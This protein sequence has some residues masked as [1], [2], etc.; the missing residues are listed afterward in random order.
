MT[1]NS[2]DLKELPTS[3]IVEY[4]LQHVVKTPDELRKEKEEKKRQN[5]DLKV[6]ISKKENFKLGTIEA[7][8]EELATDSDTHQ[9]T[10]DFINEHGFSE[11]RLNE[12]TSLLEVRTPSYER[13]DQAILIDTGEYLRALTVERRHWTER[14]IER[15]LDYL[16]GLSRL[17]LSAD[18][19]RE[20]VQGLNEITKTDV[21][22][23]TSKYQSY[24]KDRK[25]S[26]QFHGGDD[27]DIEHVREEFDAKPTRVEF[28][29]KNSPTDA[30]TGAITRDAR[31][32]VPG[33]RAGSEQLGAATI[34]SVASCFEQLDKE[35]FEIPNTP[36]MKK[37]E[38]GLVIE[39]FTTIRLE[40]QKSERMS[41]DG[42]LTHDED[43]SVEKTFVQALEEDVFD[44][45]QRYEFTEWIEDEDYLILD[46]ERHEM[47]Q[48]GIDGNDLVIH[49][50]PGTTPVT[51]KEFCRMILEEFKTTYSISS[52]TQ[53]FA[54]V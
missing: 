54:N 46:T 22:G 39:G 47:F 38:G 30:V 41:E 8:L 44:R 19:I 10:V 1:L 28:K 24:R 43:A 31:I 21:S 20:I 14:T 2:R 33:I 42:G 16:P 9:N 37:T 34:D 51:L 48:V 25:I 29:Q 50:R 5:T 12:E 13:T 35:H 45:K 49:A 6:F 18:D 26:I 53:N 32:N 23:F 11:I 4:L 36:R 7:E 52:R 3:E 17:Y 15:V 40:D 27:D